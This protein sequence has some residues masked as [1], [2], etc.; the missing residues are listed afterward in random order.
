MEWKHLMAF[1][2]NYTLPFFAY[3]RN[4]QSAWH[5]F[6]V[7]YVYVH[8]KG[9]KLYCEHSGI[10]QMLYYLQNTLPISLW[11]VPIPWPVTDK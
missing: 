9:Y 11:N 3:L 4:L 6:L 5:L 8:Y 2:K 7:V 1:K 10:L